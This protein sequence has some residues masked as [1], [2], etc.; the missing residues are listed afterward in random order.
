MRWISIAL[1]LFFV[2]FNHSQAVHAT[3]KNTFDLTLRSRVPVNDDSGL[4]H[5][6]F[7]EQ[8]WKPAETAIIVCDMW[9][10]HH[11]YNA[12]QREAEMAPRMNRLL[13][14]A[15]DMATTIIHSPSSCMPFYEDH[16]A[17]QRAKS[18]VKVANLPDK[19][20]EWCHQIPA[21]EQGVYPID[22]TDGGEDDDPVQHAKWAK[23]LEAKGLNPRAPWTRQ[24]DMLDHR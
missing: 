17:R 9:D 7:E 19:I 15:R 3:E 8:N 1:A 18:V 5:H 2:T 10:L 24:T 13:K 21:E 6:H 16:P 11:C 20:G 14:Q 12:V 22:Q 4:Y 23:D